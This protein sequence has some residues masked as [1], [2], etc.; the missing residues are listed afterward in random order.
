MLVTFNAFCPF[1]FYA[2]HKNGLA[3]ALRWKD[4]E[5]AVL[6]LLRSGLSDTQKGVASQGPFSHVGNNGVVRR[7]RAPVWERK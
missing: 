1:L 2:R 3:V 4:L 6:G 5:M 7:E